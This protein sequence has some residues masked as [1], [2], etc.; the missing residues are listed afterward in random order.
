M[1]GV[2]YK[3][4]GVD[5]AAGMDTVKRIKGMVRG[6]FTPNV[7]GDLGS[8]GGLFKFPVSK[9][10]SPI[11]VASTDGVGTKIMV[12]AAA[13]RYDTIGQ[14]LVNHC[15]NDILVQGAHPFFFLDYY[16]TGKLNPR[17]A[18]EVVKGLTIACKQSGTALLGGE[19]AEMPGLYA[20]GDFDLAGT[21]VG[22]VD[23]K[24]LITGAS[25]RP[26]DALIGLPSNGLHTNGYSLARKVLFEKKK[27][28]INRSIEALG[29][30]PADALLKPHTCYAKPV[31]ALMKKVKLNGIVHITGG[32]LTEN[33][34]RVLP[35]G[36][37]AIFNTGAW[38]VPPIFE[39]IVRDGKVPL[40]DAY[41][42][43]NMGV[44][45]VLAVRS[46]DVEKALAF[47]RKQRQKASLVGK[48]VSGQRG[49]RLD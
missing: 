45:L 29:E 4:A 15:I 46:K 11:L 30:S 49:V 37:K 20:P 47:L 17:I 40:D 19:T 35:K 26:G 23:K 5:I 9:Y 16:A 48:V 2:T 13:K 21:I 1:A 3:S 14:D 42:A 12:A 18:A 31:L 32:G 39:L 8:F 33:V 38:K 43:L 44:G 22:A 10:K 24:D 41:R 28:K 27:Y 6:T 25:I 34:P 7:M 36:C